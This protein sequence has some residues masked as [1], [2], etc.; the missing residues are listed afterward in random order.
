MRVRTGVILTLAI[1]TVAFVLITVI[2]TQAALSPAVREIEEGDAENAALQF[3]RIMEVALAAFRGICEDWGK[4]DDT[5]Y[6]MKGEN[7][8]YVEENLINETFTALRIDLMLFYDANGTLVY[9]K[10]YSTSEGYLL[11]IPRELEELPVYPGGSPGN[12][13]GDVPPV[14]GVIATG[15]DPLLVAVGPVLPNDRA[16]YAAGYILTG[17]YLDANAISHY[18]SLM[19]AQVAIRKCDPGEEAFAREEAPRGPVPFTIHFPDPGEVMVVEVPFWDLHG[20]PAFIAGITLE[21]NAYQ[22][23]REGIILFMIFV[24][25]TAGVTGL[26]AI[27][28]L[29]RNVLARIVKLEGRERDIAENRDFR[30]RTGLSGD[31]EIASLSRSIDGMLEAL[32]ERAAAEHAARENERLANAKLTLLAGITRHDVLN[33]VTVVRGFADL[34]GE[35]IPPGSPGQEFLD[36]IRVAAKTIENQLGFMREYELEASPASMA[37]IDVREMFLDVARGMGLPGVKAEVLFDDLL[38]YSDR[39]LGKIF[40]T[41]IDNS[42]SHG[43]RVSRITLSFH[44]TGEGGVLVYEDDGIGIPTDQKEIIF[45]Q[46]VGKNLGLGLYLARGILAVYGIRIRETGEYGKGARFEI[47][48]PRHLY[49]RKGEGDGVPRP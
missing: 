6:F 44:E 48:I 36:R 41:L 17:R 11:P 49:R 8:A 40:S 26:S 1:I 35:Y 10:G 46:G 19:T 9:G 47:L 45:E 15:G 31:D 27:L 42:L 18:A 29:D 25:L 33:Q 34:A 7:E 20:N 39:L 30:E 2:A 4:W 14:S 43:E 12:P 38:L 16:G 5:Y 3:T 22:I 23:A 24:I 32:E 28:F 21:R 13:A 37:W